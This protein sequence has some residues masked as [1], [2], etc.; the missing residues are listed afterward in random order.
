MT[1]PLQDQPMPED[2]KKDLKAVMQ[3]HSK[4]E[5]TVLLA[6]FAFYTGS[7]YHLTPSTAGTEEELMDLIMENMS[8]G[9]QAVVRFQSAKRRRH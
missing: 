4:V 3:R 7:L 1:R 6:A 5:P 9:Q 2:L 8:L